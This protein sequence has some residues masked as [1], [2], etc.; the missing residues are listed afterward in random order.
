MG[1]R[2][3]VHSESALDKSGQYSLVKIIAIWAAA[4]LPMV[5]LSWIVF[6]LVSPNT[7]TDPLGSAVT[8]VVLL[9]LGLMWEFVLCLIIVRREEGD[10]GWGTIKRRLWLQAPRDPKT[11]QARGRL[12]LWV[13]PALLGVALVEVVFSPTLQSIWV[14]VFPFLREPPGFDFQ[15]AL[16]SPAI[17]Q[18]L[19]GAWWFLALFLVF[20][21]FNTFLGEELLFRGIL[22]PKMEGVFGRWS[23][24]ANGLIFSLYHLHQPWGILG[25]FISTTFFFSLPAWRFRSTWMSVV[26]HS[27]QS[28]FLAFLILGIILGLA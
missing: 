19:V 11:G 26:V 17:Q 16:G 18:S 28:I 25:T 1:E 12:W 6:P 14:S 27:A 21:L 13:I 2:G 10:L 4:A 20:Q 22:L 5:I 7:V 3:V 9:T 8:R 15:V 23:W 24:V